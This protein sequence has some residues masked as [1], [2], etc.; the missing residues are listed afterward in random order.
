MLS[1]YENILNDYVEMLGNIQDDI[2]SV[3][4]N[5]PLAQHVKNALISINYNIEQK[6]K[7][8]NIELISLPL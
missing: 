7:K 2:D 1:Q 6:I 3:M 4:Y 5:E 8:I